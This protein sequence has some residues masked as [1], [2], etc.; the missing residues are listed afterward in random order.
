MSRSRS[1]HKF[2]TTDLVLAAYLVTHGFQAKHVT[3][4][5]EEVKPGHPQGAWLFPET[6]TLLDLVD[7]F[8]EGEARVDPRK[9]QGVLNQ[10]R[11]GMFKFLGIGSNG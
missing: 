4:D 3:V 10:T 9:F 1:E 11:R 7:E 2:Q 8:N 5:G 6:E